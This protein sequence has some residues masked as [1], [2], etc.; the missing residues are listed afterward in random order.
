M[1]LN[2][3]TAPYILFLQEVLISQKKT[4]IIKKLDKTLH[5]EF[6]HKF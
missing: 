4:F 5:I 3:I 2:E 6:D 1:P